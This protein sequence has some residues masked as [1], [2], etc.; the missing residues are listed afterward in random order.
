MEILSVY[1]SKILLLLYTIRYSE[2]FHVK[3]GEADEMTSR[4]LKKALATGIV[5]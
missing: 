2:K 3:H 5:V 1:Y 4:M